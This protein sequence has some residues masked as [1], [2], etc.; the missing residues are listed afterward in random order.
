[1]RDKIKFKLSDIANPDEAFSYYPEDKKPA[2]NPYNHHP[3]ILHDA[4]FVV[5][6]VFAS[7]LQDA[8]DEAVDQNK[9][10]RFQVTETELKDYITGQDAEGFDEYDGITHLGN[11]SEPFDIESLGIVEMSV[12]EFFEQLDAVELHV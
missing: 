1:M 11:A 7:N 5:C 3:F 6:V 8:L 2:F 9:L 4:G 10:D 12:T